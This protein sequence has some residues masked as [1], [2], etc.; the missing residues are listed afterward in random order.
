[1]D[2]KALGY[3]MDVSYLHCSRVIMLI[4]LV[5]KDFT[6]L[7]TGGQ[8]MT[9]STRILSVTSFTQIHYLFLQCEAKFFHFLC[10]VRVP[11]ESADHLR[12]LHDA[13]ETQA[14]DILTLENV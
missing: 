8:L 1:M 2:S 4:S 11:L 3:R 10:K 5:I 14:G 7:V 13:T 6:F 9:S 12:N